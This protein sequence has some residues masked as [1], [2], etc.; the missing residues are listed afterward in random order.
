VNPKLRAALTVLAAVVIAVVPGG[1]VAATL[2]GA[3]LAWR[4]RRLLAVPKE[5]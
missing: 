2:F 5:Q 4:R 3:W 1:L